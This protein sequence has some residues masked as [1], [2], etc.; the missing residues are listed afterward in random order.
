M[1]ITRFLLPLLFV[2]ALISCQNSK[3]KTALETWVGGEIINPITNFVVLSQS[4]CLIDTLKLD[5][6]NRF[7]FKI[8]HLQEGLHF[9]KHGH[10]NQIL[11]LEPGDSIMLRLNTFAFDESLTFSGKGASKNNFLM[12][13]YLKNEEEYSAISKLYK[14]K[15]EKFVPAIDSLHNKRLKRYHHFLEKFNPKSKFR[16]VAKASI[17]YQFYSKKELYPLFHFGRRTLISDIKLPENYYDYRKN[18]DLNN[19]T[20]KTYYPYF[21][22]LE[23][24]FDNLSYKVIHDGSVFDIRELNRN[25]Y[26]LS[27]VDSLVKNDSIKNILVYSVARK[28]ILKTNNTS[29]NKVLVSA[30]LSRNTNNSHKQEIKE[31]FLACNKLIP[32]LIIP[33]Q[34]LISVDGSIKELHKVLKKHTVIFFWSERYVRNFKNAHKKIEQLKRQHPQYD[35]IGISKDTDQNQW[36][37]T[38]K[39]MNYDELTEFRFHNTDKATKELVINAISKVFVV[40]KTGK[41]LDNKTNIFLRHFGKQLTAFLE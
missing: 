15:P 14:L 21:H 41:I 5:S 3:D 8:N 39:R 10:E 32:G 2:L 33:N 23:H 28:Y 6:R 30:V 20:L 27:L 12:E 16:D 13:M 25:L 24:Y 34:K 26:K 4:N 37:N 11:Y 19:N 38:I 22:F 17:D 36:K 40:D 31:L 35:F 29:C 1:H 7:H 9:F 18:I